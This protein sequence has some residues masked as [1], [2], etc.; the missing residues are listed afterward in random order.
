MNTMISLKDLGMVVLWGS[1]VIMLIYLALLF[2]RLN[3]TVKG[4]NKLI[5]DNSTEIGRTIQEI[6]KITQNINSITTE[7]VSSVHAVKGIIKNVG[8]LKKAATPIAKAS[9]NRKK[10][11]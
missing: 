10:A 6:P 2:K 9:K 7:A 8:I 3:D 11:D 5:E 4:V 1:L